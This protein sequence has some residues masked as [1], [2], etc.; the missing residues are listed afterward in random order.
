MFENTSRAVRAFAAICVAVSFVSEALAEADTN[1]ATAYTFTA[2]T[3]NDAELQH[4]LFGMSAVVQMSPSKFEQAA[5]SFS[6]FD[7]RTVVVDR[8]KLISDETG[9]SWVGEIRGKPGSMVVISERFGVVSGFIDD[10][11]DIFEFRTTKSGQVIMYQVDTDRLPKEQDTPMEPIGASSPVR[12]EDNRVPAANAPFT[13][14]VLMLYTTTA[15]NVYFFGNNAAIEASMYDAVASANQAYANS[16][17]DI[18][19]QVAG[20]AE[21]NYFESNDLGHTLQRLTTPTDGHMDAVHALRD[22]Y[23]ADLVALFAYGEGDTCG[24][25]YIAA[26]NGESY[27]ESAFSVTRADCTSNGTFEH[28]IG[29]NQG[30]CHDRQTHINYAQPCN[31]RAFDFA[32]GHCAGQFHTVMAYGS[33]CNNPRARFFSNPDVWFVGEPTGVD[34]DINPDYSADNSRSMSATAAAVACFRGCLRAPQLIQAVAMS[35]REI[36]VSWSD[37]DAELGYRV[38]RASAG[39]FFEPIF[40]TGNNVNNFSDSGLNPSTTYRYRIVAFDSFNEVASSEVVATTRGESAGSGG[41]S[42]SSGG[43]GGSIGLMGI[44]FTLLASFRRRRLPA[45]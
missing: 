13:Q 23:Q 6:L 39:G 2:G 8:S 7:G 30:N 4:A 20:V 29:H 28:E 3:T 32:Y 11:H 24:V 12:F 33:T 15:K 37:V 38:E 43:G 5:M 27:P 26:R 14:T 25:A 21:V 31:E 18:S 35:S 10:G 9:M 36:Q 22:E 44:V 42:G 1:V 16:S 19:L 34:Y 17:V 41:N 40:E 45:G